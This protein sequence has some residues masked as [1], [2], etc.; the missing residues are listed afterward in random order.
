MIQEFLRII[1]IAGR[2][3]YRSEDRTGT[4]V[5]KDFIN[6]I[7]ASGHL[8]VVEHNTITVKIKT[9]RGITHELVRHRLVSYSQESTRYC[10]YS[11]DKFSKSIT[12]ILPWS[13]RDWT[14][15]DHLIEGMYI[16]DPES[17]RII[18]VSGSEIKDTVEN[19]HNMYMNI[20][21][22]L[23]AEEA[24]FDSITKGKSPQ[25]ARHILPTCLKAEI[26][27]S[28]N[29]REWMHIFKERR[30]Q[31]AHPDIRILMEKVKEKFIEAGLYM[32]A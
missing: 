2:T 17:D 19:S 21:S 26:V 25:F 28:A 3:C 29:I 4:D 16:K 8:S 27:M 32:F 23:T 20:N 14:S 13:C 10:N 12:V 24:Y 9:D 7:I 11:K 22:L 5:N 30:S 1:E 18:I 15:D 31:R 6:K